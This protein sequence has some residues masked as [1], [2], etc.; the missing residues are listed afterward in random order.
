MTRPKDIGTAFET[1]CVKF[2]R[3]NGF[4]GAERRALSGALDKGDLLVC[5][6]VIAECKAWST[7]TDGNIADWWDETAREKKNANASVALLVVKRP[8]KPVAQ[9]WCWRT[10]EWG[11][12]HAQWF[13]HAVNE[14]RDMGWGDPR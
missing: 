12:Y 2:L 4:P 9:A 7:V 6:G 3:D 5:P 14:L 10:T 13:G 11:F 8:R 1:A